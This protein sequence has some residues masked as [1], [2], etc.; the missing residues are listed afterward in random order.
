MLRPIVKRLCAPA[1]Q[2][3]LRVNILRRSAGSG[4]R[5]FYFESIINDSNGL[6]DGG[7]EVLRVLHEGGLLDVLT[8]EELIYI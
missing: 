2:H 4:G 5:F 3:P 7:Q 6:V 8:V 1:Q